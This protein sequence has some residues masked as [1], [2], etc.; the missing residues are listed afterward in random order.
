M[1]HDLWLKM[2]QYTPLVEMIKPEHHN[3][4]IKLEENIWLLKDFTSE[5]ERKNYLDFVNTIEEEK[6]WEKNRNWWV[7]KYF[8]IGPEY[9]IENTAIKLRDNLRKLISEDVSLGSF[10]SIHRLKE[11]FGMFLHTD[12][13]SEKGRPLLEEDGQVVGTIEGH[14]NYCIL[15]VVTYLNDFNGGEIYFPAL[16]FKY[17]GNAGD[18][19]IFPGTGKEYD[20]GVKKVEAGPI[21]Y[22]TTAFGYDPRVEALKAK[23]YVFEDVETGELDTLEPNKAINNPEEAMKQPPRL[24]W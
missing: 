7:G 15:A 20:H 14:N 19:L 23:N 9:E 18:L 8:P 16:N 6:W 3:K 1:E 17:K 13:P 24:V 5:E 10:G 21:R 4:F 2:T 12:N 22:I 11:G